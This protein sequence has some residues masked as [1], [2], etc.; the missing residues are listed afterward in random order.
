LDEGTGSFKVDDA[1]DIA[2]TDGK[3]FAKGL[4]KVG[5][6]NLREVAGRRTGDPPRG[7]PP[8]GRPPRRP[9]RPPLTP[10]F[11][12]PRPP[13]RALSDRRRRFAPA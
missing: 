3:V 2:G 9:R 12:Q 7:R 6:V 13:S 1:V 5:S 10:P 8:R 4:T 11:P